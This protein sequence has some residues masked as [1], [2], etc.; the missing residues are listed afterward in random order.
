MPKMKSN[1]A[2]AKRFRTSASGKFRRQKAYRR[3]NLT[4]KTRARK[5]TLR[6]K[7]GVSPSDWG[8]IRRLLPTA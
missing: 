1:R 8:R 7:T 6:E 3:H 5:R 4:K 2:A